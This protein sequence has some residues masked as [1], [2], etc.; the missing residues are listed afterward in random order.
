MPFAAEFR[1]AAGTFDVEADEVEGLHV[2][3]DAALSPDV[4]T[5]GALT[6]DTNSLVDDAQLDGTSDATVLRDLAEECRRRAEICDQALADFQA[7]QAA[8]SQHDREV[9]SWRA[10]N[11]RHQADPDA[12]PPG[13]FPSRPRAPQPAHSWVE[14]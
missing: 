2:P 9:T 13:R 12:P 14:F 6:A 5:G 4:L 8:L 3:M 1:S 10:D 11:R 7:Y